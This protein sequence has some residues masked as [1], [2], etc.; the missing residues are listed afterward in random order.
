MAAGTTDR[1]GM[2]SSG[3]SRSWATRLMLRPLPA[4]ARTPAGASLTQTAPP[5]IVN[6]IADNDLR[7][8]VLVG[9]SYGGT[10]IAKVAEAVPDR[11][12]RLVFWSAF[13]LLD[14]QSLLDE[15]PQNVA[16]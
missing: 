16:I 7:D 11:I 8:F 5:S 14:G 1:A 15:T 9:H 4:M 6:Y 12:E 3:I 10:I 2:M 13:V